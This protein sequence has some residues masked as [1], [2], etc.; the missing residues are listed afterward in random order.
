MNGPSF[1]SNAKSMPNLPGMGMWYCVALRRVGI[2]VIGSPGRI[3]WPMVG[4]VVGVGKHGRCRWEWECWQM[5]REAEQGVEEMVA[6]LM[7]L[8]PWMDEED[9]TLAREAFRAHFRLVVGEEV[10]VGLMAGT[11]LV[12]GQRAEAVGDRRRAWGVEPWDGWG[13]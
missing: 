5:D 4:S 10:D 11:L 8:C 7:L 6:G 12:L 1:P 13:C 2:A 3:W 9:V